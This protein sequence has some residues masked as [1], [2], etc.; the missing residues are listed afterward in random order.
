MTPL[1]TWWVPQEIGRLLMVSNAEMDRRW[2]L[3]RMVMAREGL[4]WFIGGVGMP[5]GYAKWL[6][7]RSTKGTVVVMNGVAFPLEG[8]AVKVTLLVYL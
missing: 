1:G 8:R 5:G 2:K 6:S 4:D 3:V 7:N